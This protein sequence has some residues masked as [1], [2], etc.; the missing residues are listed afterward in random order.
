MK[1]RKKSKPDVQYDHREQTI[2]DFYDKNYKM[3]RVSQ[4]NIVR[5][6]ST[7][8]PKSIDSVAEKKPGH[9]NIFINFN[10]NRFAARRK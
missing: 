1:Y 7:T 2:S 8:A 3:T 6:A 4:T 9:L 5:P 10:L